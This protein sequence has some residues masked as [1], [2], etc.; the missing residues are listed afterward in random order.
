M[1]DGWPGS[2]A[3]PPAVH[4]PSVDPDRVL[5]AVDEELDKLAAAGP[6]SDELARQVARWSAALHHEESAV[7]SKVPNTPEA[8]ARPSSE[9]DAV[10]QADSESEKQPHEEASQQAPSGAPSVLGE[11][12]QRPVF[13]HPSTEY[14][15][16]FTVAIMQLLGE[17]LITGFAM[18][19]P[20]L[21]RQFLLSPP[22][23][24]TAQ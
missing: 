24:W 13:R 23:L 16:I 9:G 21:L 12:P 10:V 4:P 15:F 19:L 2:D 5:T 6:G 11:E 17:Y 1:R 7:R 18:E 20:A 8:S 14:G 3:L 22:H